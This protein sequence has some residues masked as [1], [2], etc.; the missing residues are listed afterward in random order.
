MAAGVALPVLALVRDRRQNRKSFKQLTPLWRDLTSATPD[1]TL[2]PSQLIRS[3]AIPFQ[4]RLYRRPIEIRDAMIV[5]RN[6]VT[7][8]VLELANQ[9]VRDQGVPAHLG[10]SHIASCWLSAA[11]LAKGKGAAPQSQAANLAGPGANDLTEE[12]SHLLHIAAAYHSPTVLAYK[13]S[14]ARTS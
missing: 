12:I 9:H 3:I 6:Y 13:A 1:V 10:D 4:L 5:L 7:A 11:V 8:D 14:L 2:E